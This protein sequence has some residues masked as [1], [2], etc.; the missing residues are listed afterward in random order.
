MEFW[1]IWKIWELELELGRED[2]RKGILGG[3]EMRRRKWGNASVVS[4]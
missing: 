3:S 4:E 1:K 2:I